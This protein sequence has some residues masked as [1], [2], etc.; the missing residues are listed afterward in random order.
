MSERSDGYCWHGVSIHEHCGRCHIDGITLP[1]PS[2]VEAK[3]EFMTGYN[4]VPLT[5]AASLTPE[6]SLG[7]KLIEAASECLEPREWFLSGDAVCMEVDDTYSATVQPTAPDNIHVIEHSAYQK[8]ERELAEV[9]E[10]RLIELAAISTAAMC[11]TAKS[12]QEQFIDKDNPYWT[13]AYG[14]VIQAVEREMV[15]IE[16]IAGLCELVKS[17][18][19]EC[20]Y[21]PFTHEY[22]FEC[23]RCEAL[24]RFG[25]GE[26][27]GTDLDI[28][29]WA[30]VGRMSVVVVIALFT[31]IGFLI[32]LGIVV[33][34][35]L[36]V[37]GA[38]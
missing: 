8:L 9:K 26:V 32:S 33:W 4:Y 25:D 36:R 3:G 19:C 30:I 14:D 37:T 28:I 2:A 10:K 7:Q 35:F 23:K 22:F 31:E 38:I 16:K 11:N 24:K 27:M 5:T 17:I 29:V 21:K 15:L 20:K 13:V 34:A 12:K 18:K 1:A 6:P